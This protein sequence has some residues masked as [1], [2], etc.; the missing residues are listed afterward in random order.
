MTSVTTFFFFHSQIAQIDA[1]TIRKRTIS[2]F[3]LM[4]DIS[5]VAE[6]CAENL[7]PNT[8]SFVLRGCDCIAD[9][10]LPEAGSQSREKPILYRTKEIK[11]Y[12]QPAKSNGNQVQGRLN[13]FLEAK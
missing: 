4:R 7:H 11:G 10:A 3:F 1:C 8:I 5:S 6:K 2:A 13:L 9:S 12:R